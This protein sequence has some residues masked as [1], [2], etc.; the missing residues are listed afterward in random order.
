MSDTMHSA[1][2][3]LWE[4]E[5]AEVERA[6]VGPAPNRMEQRAGVLS[7][8]IGI[9]RCVDMAKIADAAQKEVQS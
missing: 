5:N 8:V 1:A 6:L 3:S 4:M 9:A 7:A 2:E